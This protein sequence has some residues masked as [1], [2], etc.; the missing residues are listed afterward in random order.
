MLRAPRLA[1][2]FGSKPPVPLTPVLKMPMSTRVNP[3]RASLTTFV[4]KV[5]V[6]PIVKPRELPN[7]SPAEG[8]AGRS[9]PLG[10][11]PS[12]KKLSRWRALVER[13]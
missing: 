13:L 12:G 1:E 4:P 10:D 11:A 7:S 6:S 9:L 3:K 2:T 5:C 8:P